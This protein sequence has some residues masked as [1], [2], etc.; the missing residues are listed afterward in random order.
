MISDSYIDETNFLLLVIF[1]TNNAL[2]IFPSNPITKLFGFNLYYKFHGIGF[3]IYCLVHCQVDLA[4]IERKCLL[5]RQL[6]IEIN[7]NKGNM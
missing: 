1:N 5:H 3:V 2:S 6:D 4:L 7:E